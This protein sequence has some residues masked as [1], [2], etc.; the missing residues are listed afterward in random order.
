MEAFKKFEELTA[1][2]ISEGYGLTEASPLAIANPPF[3]RRKVGSIG[4]PRPAT[5]ARIVDLETG[6]ITLPPGMEGELCL[7]GPQIMK[8]YWNRPEETA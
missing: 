1:G 4:I 2:K 7:K 6:E 5:D 8:G 3:G